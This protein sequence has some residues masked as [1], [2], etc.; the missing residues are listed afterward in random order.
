MTLKNSKRS[1]HQIWTVRNHKV[2]K[3]LYFCLISTN[4]G[5]MILKKRYNFMSVKAVLTNFE[6]LRHLT[7]IW[8]ALMLL[9][10]INE[11]HYLL[12]I[13]NSL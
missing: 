9:S 7:L 6:Y 2:I 12:E 10:L 3:S 1:A 11:V 8:K 5:N 4:Q 13:K